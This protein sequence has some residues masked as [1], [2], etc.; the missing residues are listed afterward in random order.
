MKGEEIKWIT[1][2]CLYAAELV[3]T[4]TH[5]RIW[6]GTAVGSQV[7]QEFFCVLLRSSKPSMIIIVGFLLG[8][9][10]CMNSAKTVGL[11]LLSF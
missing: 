7:S 11:L 5:M 8:I 2:I 10:F 1:R 6:D 4:K 9:C 3:V